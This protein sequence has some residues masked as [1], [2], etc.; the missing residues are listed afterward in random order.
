[1][2]PGPHDF[3]PVGQVIRLQIHLER[4]APDKSLYHS[5]TPADH[6]CQVDALRCDHRGV[7]GVMADGSL[8]QDLHHKDHP[9]SRFRRA[10]DISLMLSGHYAKIRE[11]FGDHMVDG[12]AGENVLVDFDEIMT[13]DD[14][15][16]GIVIGDDDR[17][18]PIEAWRI[19]TPCAPFSRLAAKVSLDEKPDR[20]VTEALTFLNHGMR[21]FY[22]T[23][24]EHLTSPV[25]IRVGDTV[26]RQTQAAH[27]TSL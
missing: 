4:I 26:Y 23:L 11:K 17:Q 21:G 1:M 8:Q 14:L 3:V 13:I 10:N 25:D 18:L 19:A 5:P 27:R 12:I 22:G 7:C 24:A 16:S 6:L 15:A 20:R 9:Q 2:T